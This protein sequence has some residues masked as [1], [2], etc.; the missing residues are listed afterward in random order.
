M[1]SLIVKMH[2]WCQNLNVYRLIY[3]LHLKFNK[4]IIC[5]LYKIDLIEPEVDGNR[6]IG[7]NHRN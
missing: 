2:P 3:F 7:E 4:I 1:I 6:E 5:L